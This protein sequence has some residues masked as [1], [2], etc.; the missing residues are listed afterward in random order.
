MVQSTVGNHYMQSQPWALQQVEQE[1][2]KL[3][4]TSPTTPSSNIHTCPSG[5]NW[6]E[7]LGT[8]FDWSDALQQAE[9]YILPNS[10]SQ[11]R[12]NHGLVY[13]S[14]PAALNTFEKSCVGG[15]TTW[16]SYGLNGLPCGVAIDGSVQDA[17]MSPSPKSYV[18]DEFGNTYGPGS[19]L[20]Q[21]SPTGNWNGYPAATPNAAL[22]SPPY[23]LFHA[24]KMDSDVGLSRLPRTNASMGMT[25]IPS[26]GSGRQDPVLIAPF[27]DDQQSGSEYSHSQNSSA[28]HSPWYHVNYSY[29]V[30]NIPYRPRDVETCSKLS[31]DTS[32]PSTSGAHSTQYLSAPWN[33]SR[34]SVHPQSHVQDRFRM[35]R[36]AGAQAQREHNDQVLIEGKKRGETY[37]EIKLRM[38]GEK[39]AESTLRGRYRSLTK[40]RKDRVRKPIWTKIDL[41]LLDE[42]VQQEFDRIES[43]LQNPYSISFDQK[44]SKVAWKKVAEFIA[45]N[46]GS[47]HFGNA[48]CKRRWLERNP[49][50]K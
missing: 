2:T 13:N 18:S 23:T 43:N 27:D 35:S 42:S 19:M 31:S 22:S 20:D 24:Q 29:D 44:I 37:K 46:G 38:I 8:S 16:P 40:A 1:D 36:S 26:N 4:A 49:A 15:P 17:S 48:T 3:R 21:A 14:T 45:D 34:P 28:R 10:E 25:T 7:S 50:R 30:S 41:E 11:F 32:F 39:P 6:S 9:T 5:Q 12:Q 47:Y 33:D